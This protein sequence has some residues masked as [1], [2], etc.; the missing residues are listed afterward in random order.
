VLIVNDV[1]NRPDR[2][3]KPVRFIGAGENPFL[4]KYKDS[5]ELKREKCFFAG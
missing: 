4:K 2:F 1:K 5:F 3:P